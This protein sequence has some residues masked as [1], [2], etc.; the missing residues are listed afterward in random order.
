MHQDQTK[1]VSKAIQAAKSKYYTKRLSNASMKTTF[2]ILNSIQHKGQKKLPRLD[3]AICDAFSTLFISRLYNIMIKI[4]HVHDIVK[5]QSI[6]SP[7][8]PLPSCL[9]PPP[10]HFQPTNEVELSKIILT[11]PTKSCLFVA[12]PTSL[13]RKTQ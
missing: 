7:S 12:L 8:L 11:G 1:I 10:Q 6:S 9:P 5:S 13:L 4:H 2:K 3:Q